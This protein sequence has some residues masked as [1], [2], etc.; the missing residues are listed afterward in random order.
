MRLGFWQITSDLFSYKNPYPY[1][2][3][4]Y[5]NFSE[6]FREAEIFIPGFSTP[7]SK[8]DIFEK[9]KMRTFAVLCFVDL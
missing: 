6:R 1:L 3:L 8:R 5:K 2:N 7:V 9:K 4:E